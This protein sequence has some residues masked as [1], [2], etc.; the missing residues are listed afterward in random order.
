MR[1]VCGCTASDIWSSSQPWNDKSADSFAD[2]SSFILMLRKKEVQDLVKGWSKEKCFQWQGV[3]PNF[4]AE[5]QLIFSILC[6][7]VINRSLETNDSNGRCYQAGKDSGQIK[8]FVPDLRGWKFLCRYCCDSGC[9]NLIKPPNTWASIS[10]CRTG[11]SA[12]PRNHLAH[13]VSCNL[14]SR[15]FRCLSLLCCSG[16][17]GHMAV[18]LGCSPGRWLEPGTCVNCKTNFTNLVI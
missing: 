1:T 8:Q 16:L 11:F 15:G 7:H 2:S 5:H 10:T 3:S 9:V 17:A 6:Y 13:R 18:G 4:E 14:A 12:I